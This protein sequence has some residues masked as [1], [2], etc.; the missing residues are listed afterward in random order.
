MSANNFINMKFTIINCSRLVLEFVLTN[1]FP[2]EDLAFEEKYETDPAKSNQ[3]EDE[4]T[5]GVKGVNL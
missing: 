3:R 5:V 1:W 2:Y 4:I